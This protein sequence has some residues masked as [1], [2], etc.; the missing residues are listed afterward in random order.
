MKSC[1]MDYMD[2]EGV[3]VEVSLTMLWSGNVLDC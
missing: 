3:I 1:D 2:F